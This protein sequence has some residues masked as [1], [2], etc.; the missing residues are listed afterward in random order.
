[1]REQDIKPQNILVYKS[2][3]LLTDFGLALDWSEQSGS[4]TSG[5]PAG[6]SPRYAAPEV[7]NHLPRSSPS[8]VWSLGCVFL[9]MYAALQDKPPKE[10][11]DFQSQKGTRTHF[12]WQNTEATELWIESLQT[13]R[14][15]PVLDIIRNMLQPD[16]DSRPSS[17]MVMNRLRETTATGANEFPFCGSCCEEEDDTDESV[18]SSEDE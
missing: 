7:A 3:P 9:E 15:H 11:E 4:T 2:V 6:F 5:A 13:T 14:G 17:K 10:L 12:F 8:D 1:M 18:Y 16:R